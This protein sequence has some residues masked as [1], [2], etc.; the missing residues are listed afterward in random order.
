MNML[1]WCLK[2]LAAVLIG[3]VIGLFIFLALA[4]LAHSECLPTAKA[5]WEAHP[6]S[7]ATWTSGRSGKCW[8][9]RGARAEARRVEPLGVPLPRPAARP[10]MVGTAEVVPVIRNIVAEEHD[11][12]RVIVIEYPATDPN[13][14]ALAWSVLQER[15]ISVG[16]RLWLRAS[17]ERAQLSQVQL[18]RS[19]SLLSAATSSA[20]PDTTDRGL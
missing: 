15:M 13:P 12:F 18:Q 7:H 11:Q 2:Y 14:D 5:V 1:W 9:A 4:K 8:Y 20:G 6:G 16:W 10:R 3:S 17:I 19:R